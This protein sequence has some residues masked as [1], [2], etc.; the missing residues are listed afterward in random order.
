[1]NVTSDKWISRLLGMAHEVASW[2]KD[3][4]TKVG[5]IITTEDGRPMSWGFNG[6]PMGVDDSIPGRHERPAKYKWTAHAEQNAIDMSPNHDL[7]DTVLFVTFFPCSGCARTIIQKKIKTLVV[8]SRFTVSK[9]P[10]RWAED[11]KISEEMLREAGVE[12][13]E[14]DIAE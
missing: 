13:I 1:M 12:I 7:S 4:S 3:D 8:D 5:A 6:F 14:G 9:V 2:S 10:E 11:M